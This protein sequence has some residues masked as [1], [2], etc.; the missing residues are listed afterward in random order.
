MTMLVMADVQLE[1]GILGELSPRLLSGLRL[2]PVTVD[3]G[4]GE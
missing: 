1:G 2:R 3:G 4:E